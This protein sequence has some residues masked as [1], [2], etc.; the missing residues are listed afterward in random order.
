MET[1]FLWVGKVFCVVGGIAI[2][3]FLFFLF[4]ELA[5]EMWKIFS[6]KFRAVCKAE[7]LIFEYKK[8]RKEFLQWLDEKQ[9]EA[10]G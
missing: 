3:L 9:T 6:G 8:N 4:L 10:D 5:L 2:A 1:V 7:S